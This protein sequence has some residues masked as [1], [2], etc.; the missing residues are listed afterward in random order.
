MANKCAL[1][2]GLGELGSAGRELA[3]QVQLWPEVFAIGV[4]SVE[5]RGVVRRAILVKYMGIKSV[6]LRGACDERAYYTAVRM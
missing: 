5:C 6:R 1:H 4:P 3:A 2:V